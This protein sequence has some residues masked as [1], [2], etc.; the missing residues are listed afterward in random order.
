M[1]SLWQP[2]GEA[3]AHSLHPNIMFP[4]MI[5]GNLD[6]APFQQWRA[7]WGTPRSAEWNP[8]FNMPSGHRELKVPSLCR[9][10]KVS[11]LCR[12]PPKRGYGGVNSPNTNSLVWGTLGMGLRAFPA[13][14]TPP[15]PAHCLTPLSRLLARYG[16][17][18]AH[19]SRK[20]VEDSG[21]H[22]TRSPELREA[23]ER[24]FIRLLPR[25]TAEVAE[26]L[27]LGFC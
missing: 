11:S 16:R 17:L 10:L 14:R 13:W 22:S 20:V 1:V 27:M 6:G 9:K 12:A 4:L 24:H 5:K 25:P 7:A 26:I 19:R 8:H 21:L 2:G 15:V 23:E 3:P 18:S